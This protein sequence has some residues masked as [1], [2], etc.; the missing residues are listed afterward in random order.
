M[1]I[2]ILGSPSPNVYTILLSSSQKYLT[3]ATKGEWCKKTKSSET[4]QKN[5]DQEMHAKS[6]SGKKIP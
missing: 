5:F 4:F 6:Q 3:Y 2:I 1:R